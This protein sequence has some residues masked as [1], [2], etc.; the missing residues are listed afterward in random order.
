M[1]PFDVC[2]AF[3]A[4]TLL[5]GQ[6]EEHPACK[7]EWWGAGVVICLGRGAHL[8]IARLYQSHSL[9]LQKIQIGFGFTFPVLAHPGSPGQNPDSHKM[10]AVVVVVPLDV[11]ATTYNSYNDFTC[12]FTA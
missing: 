4:L 11:R 12:L 2:N 6:Q 7:N 1:F 5:V 10:V 8:H 9:S 3:S